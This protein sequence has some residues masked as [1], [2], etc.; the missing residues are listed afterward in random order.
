MK[1]DL[2]KCISILIPYRKNSSKITFW[3]QKRVS[4]EFSG[5]QEFPGGH[6]EPD[7]SAESAAIRETLEETG[8]AIDKKDIQLFKIVKVSLPKKTLSLSVFLTDQIESFSP[9]GLVTVNKDD[10][11]EELISTLPAN[12][13]IIR[14]VMDYLFRV[15]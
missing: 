11:L 14:D 5:L 1:T 9:D 12:Y 2:I 15:G 8:V 4:D 10:N 7:E 6:I 13:Q 3:F